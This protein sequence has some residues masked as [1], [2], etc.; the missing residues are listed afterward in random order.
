MNTENAETVKVTSARK[1]CESCPAQWEGITDDGR[2]V[3][4]H[5]RWGQLTVYVMPEP[6]LEM[7]YS[8]NSC[9]YE[10]QL[11]GNYDG[12]LTY[13]QLQ[14]ATKGVLEWP[15][16]DLQRATLHNTIDLNI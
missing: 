4:A 7:D 14:A 2:E 5:Y 10:R 12:K 11:G 9:I 13:Q 6:G 1:T 8:I 3:Y 15:P 16:T